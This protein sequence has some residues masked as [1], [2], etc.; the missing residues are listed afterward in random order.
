MRVIARFKYDSEAWLRL[1]QAEF[2]ATPGHV[3]YAKEHSD[4]FYTLREDAEAKYASCGIPFLRKLSAGETL[5]DHI[6]TWRKEEYKMF[7]F[8]V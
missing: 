7:P 5:A 8:D 4:M 3:A 1:S 2:S 6:N